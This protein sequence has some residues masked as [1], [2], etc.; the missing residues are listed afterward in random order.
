MNEIETRSGTYTGIKQDKKRWL[1]YFNEGGE[2]E[3]KYSAFDPLLNLNDLKIG[4]NYKYK[5]EHVPMPK[6]QG[7]FY[8]NL[9]RT[10]RDAAFAIEV[11]YKPAQKQPTAQNT[12]AP[13]KK[14]APPT[15]APP[16][17]IEYS[18]DDYWKAKEQRDIANEAKRDK[19]NI[20]REYGQRRGGL[21]HD[22]E[23]LLSSLIKS[24]AIKVSSATGTCAVDKVKDALKATAEYHAILT[25]YLMEDAAKAEAKFRE[26]LANGSLK[27]EKAEKKSMQG[28][29]AKEQGPEEYLG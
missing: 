13:E 8:H 29:P 10:G 6:E 12:S 7:K 17:Q 19:Q 9:A 1:L 22:A 4:Q 2:E 21:A 26:E 23:G 28:Q 24:G 14:A 11:A 3:Q 18:K 5:V 16:A 27:P 25:G 15:I 20:E